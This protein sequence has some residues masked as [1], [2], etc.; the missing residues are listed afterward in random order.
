MSTD[1]ATAAEFHLM[2][3]LE[4]N[5]RQ[6]AWVL[7]SIAVL[8]LV[9]SFYTWKKGQREV[10]AGEAFSNIRLSPEAAPSYLKLATEYPGTAAGE[11][12]VL[13]AAGGSFIAGNYTEALS[14]F[15]QLLREY[16]DSTFRTQALLGTA[17][18]LDAQGKIAEATT[19]YQDL[20]ERWPNDPTTVQAKSALA[21]LYERQNQ[22]ERALR[23][24]E[25]LARTASFS[26]HGLLA[27]VL[28]QDLLARHPELA[29]A[30]SPAADIKLP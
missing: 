22:P 3:W 17:A 25:E 29:R 24:Y 12:A 13:L 1:I 18:C 5:K 11:R 14:R 15:E 8:A 16:P 19:R 27:S 7:G 20:I 28:M 21:R 2:G 9:I 30:K 10:E 23:L 26:T 4:K 6:V